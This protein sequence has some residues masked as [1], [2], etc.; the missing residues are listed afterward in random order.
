MSEQEEINEK[1]KEIE[2]E[3]KRQQ[4]IFEFLEKV[5]TKDII[6]ELSCTLTNMFYYQEDSKLKKIRSQLKAF[7]KKVEGGE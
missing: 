7:I 5:V 4:I 2:A 3:I 1:I 6:G